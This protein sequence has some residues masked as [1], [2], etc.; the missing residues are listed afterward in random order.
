MPVRRFNYPALRRLSKQLLLGPQA[1]RLRQLEHAEALLHRIHQG[2]RY[3]FEHVYEGI[4]TYRDGEGPAR[5]MDGRELYADIMHLCD[6]LSESLKLRAQ[7][8]QERA[9]TMEDLVEMFNVSLRTIS[10]WSRMGLVQRK[11]IFPD[12]RRRI[13]FLQRHVDAFLPRLGRCSDRTDLLRPIAD[14]ERLRMETRA[15]ELVADRSLSFG[16]IARR[17]AG[18]FKRSP[19][20]ARYVLV[21]HCASHD[22]PLRDRLSA[23]QLDDRE[24][25][26]I[27][28][29]IESGKGF[30]DVA[31]T[32]SCSRASVQRAYFRVAARHIMEEPI[33]YVHN[34]MFENPKADKII[35]DVPM[36]PG[37][38]ARARRK[39]PPAGSEYFVA[40]TADP[41]G[42]EPLLTKEQ[43]Q[44]LFRR[45]NYLKYK[46]SEL[47]KGLVPSRAKAGLVRRIRDLWSRAVAIKQRLIRANLG[48]VIS[49]ARRHLGP[50]NN[51]GK[52]IS[53]GNYSL[54]LAI[55]KFDFGRG[56]R[57]STY[58]SWAIMKNY[59]KSI[60]EESYQLENFVTGTQELME[61][62][63]QARHLGMT[64]EERLP[65][66]R[67]EM[68]RF[69]NKLS[70]RERR[71]LVNRFGLFDAT[72]PRTLE[73]V[74]NIFDLSKERIRQI[75][76]RALAK[77][78]KIMDKEKLEALLEE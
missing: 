19:Q 27:Y 21:R 44:D 40:M 10:R 34:E 45:Y 66:L 73:Q 6:A 67:D 17:V 23:G 77:L 1:V 32:Y 53:D 7:D 30:D 56:F 22:G 49:I 60:P 24:K 2:E 3:S 8:L 31:G 72:P 76:D 59:A 69:V 5:L 33:S 29:L 50:R 16:D 26:K 13:A 11:L 58:A 68:R 42:Q 18:D 15:N 14:E 28:Q 47:R 70:D 51:L 4:T 25:E 55:E 37:K 57:F 65:H 38:K 74:G 20:T 41:Q 46:V 64:K 43:E 62:T 52:L 63:G 39:A 78:R 36:P 12:G 54:M 9:Y 35:L 48:L 71:I 61:G 75:E